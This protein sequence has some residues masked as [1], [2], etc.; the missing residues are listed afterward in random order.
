MKLLTL[1][2]VCDKVGFGRSHVIRLME[3]EKYRHLEFPKATKVGIK[4]LTPEHEI[5]EW[6]VKQLAKR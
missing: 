1:K 6:I 4:R 2:Q 3:D 5:D